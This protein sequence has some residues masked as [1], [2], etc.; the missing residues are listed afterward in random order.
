LFTA[1]T[2]LL[3]VADIL[4]VAYIIYRVVRALKGTRAFR[5]VRGIAVILAVYGTATLLNLQLLGTIFAAVNIFQVGIIALVIIFAPEIKD[6]LARIGS[7]ATLREPPSPERQR[8]V[9]EIVKACRGMAGRRVG[10]L[11]ALQRDDGLE[12]V[13]GTGTRIHGRVSASFIES[14]FYPGNPLHDGAVVVRGND[15]VAAK[16]QLPLAEN[17]EPAAEAEAPGGGGGGPSFGMR[18]RAALGL[19]EQRDAV[20]V[21]VSEER[22]TIS[23]CEGG[24]IVKD[25]DD[26]RLRAD[27]LRLVAG[28]TL[29]APRPAFDLRLALGG[30]LPT[31]ALALALAILLW[32]GQPRTVE[33]PL[34]LRPE[35]P[36]GRPFQAGDRVVVDASAL[37]RVPCRVSGRNYEVLYLTLRGDDEV[38]GL[39]RLEIGRDETPRPAL[40]QPR[41]TRLAV[42]APALVVDVK[43]LAEVPITRAGVIGVAFAGSPDPGLELR[44]WSVN[45]RE[46]SAAVLYPL[47]LETEVLQALKACRTDPP[48]ALPGLRGVVSRSV[49]VRLPELVRPGGARIPLAAWN[50]HLSL[51]AT[52]TVDV[53]PPA[54]A[55]VTA[56]APAEDEDEAELEERRAL[57]VDAEATRRAAEL[58]IEERKVS[59]DVAALKAPPTGRETLTIEDLAVREELVRQREAALDKARAELSLWERAVADRQAAATAALGRAAEAAP[60]ARPRLDAEVKRLARLAES[61]LKL[62]AAWAKVVQNGERDR[63]LYADLRDVTRLRLADALAVRDRTQAI[64]AQ[65]DEARRAAVENEAGKAAAI[66]RAVAPLEERL[67]VRE[68]EAP[69]HAKWTPTGGTP[70]MRAKDAL[71]WARKV[72]ERRA[73][74]LIDARKDVERRR[75]ELLRRAVEVRLLTKQVE[76]ETPRVA[77]H[78]FPELA[79]LSVDELKAKRDLL[80]AEFERDRPALDVAR[81]QA[82]AFRRLVEVKSRNLGV[83][84]RRLEAHAESFR[85]PEVQPVLEEIARTLRALSEKDR[86]L[87]EAALRETVDTSRASS[88]RLAELAK[89]RTTAS[90]GVGAGAGAP[91]GGAPGAGAG[92]G[93]GGAAPAPPP[94]LPPSLEWLER[95]QA[96]LFDQVTDAARDRAALEALLDLFPLVESAAKAYEEVAAA[97]RRAAPP[98]PDDPG[99]PRPGGTPPP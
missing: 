21:V 78:R 81:E 87:V 88:T 2:L 11:I 10:A 46:E 57:E 42:E 39:G 59:A 36:M 92:G 66:A 45:F 41:W 80:A 60:A 29:E 35:S 63:R 38:R 99:P 18:H 24:R 49:V 64:V 8:T 40:E 50:R 20:A 15:V 1:S 6:A 61:A 19:S 89:E 31:K 76:L 27:L 43:P 90:T 58:D 95:E 34:D 83:L 74:E 86:P 22:G 37:Q 28:G 47:S 68:I 48:I 4:L 56:G 98:G 16:C 9:D 12:D 54:A 67:R 77:D 93:A 97:G 44:G 72:H 84:A 30:E 52:V 82:E 65:G 33:V 85:G 23:L 91:P 79:R 13:V 70:E 55:G 51:S 53:A 7:R 3:A 5:L 96:L 17:L 75:T 14:I 26:E 73:Q 69:A 94:R 25:L 62:R 71:E 32:A